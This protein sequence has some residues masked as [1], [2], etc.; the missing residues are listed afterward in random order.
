MFERQVKVEK[1]TKKQKLKVPP[2]IQTPETQ[3]GGQQQGAEREA[4]DPV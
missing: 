1:Q 4:T 2:T 3:A